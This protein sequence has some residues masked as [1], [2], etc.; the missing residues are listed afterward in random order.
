MR[1]T[2]FGRS[3]SFF[4]EENEPLTICKQ[5]RNI[6]VQLNTESLD[7]NTVHVHRIVHGLATCKSHKRLNFN[8]QRSEASLIVHHLVEVPLFRVHRQLIYI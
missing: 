2:F 6:F 7:E 1:E 8:N 5:L 4:L 3:P